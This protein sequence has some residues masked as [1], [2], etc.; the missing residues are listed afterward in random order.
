MRL[1]TLS[2]LARTHGIAVDNLPTQNTALLRPHVQIMDD[3][4]DH[5]V[6]LAKFK[7]LRHF[8][9]SPEAVARLTYEAIVDAAAD[10]VRYLELRFSP[11]ALARVQ[12]FPLADVTDW[13]IEATQQASRVCQIEV[14]LIVTLLRHE[15]LSLAQEVARVAFDRADKG[16]VGLDLAGDEVKFSAMP[17]REIFQEANLRQMGV[18][19]HAGEWTNADSVRI[20]VEE[21]GAVRLGHG[22]RVIDDE[23]V[24]EM[25]RGRQ[26]ALELCLTSNVQ[27]GAVRSM[28]RHPAGE[29][30]RRGALVTL[31]TDDPCVSDCTL[32]DEYVAAVNDLDFSVGELHQVTK[33]AAQA[34]FLPPA[35]RL[36]LE[37]KVASWFAREAVPAF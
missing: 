22:V 9:R 25:V 15:E 13:V 19:I 34:A 21:M 35:R 12:G 7:V 6:F 16:I 23:E 2:D 4:Q 29:L 32:T 5:E 3:P 20:A 18:T 36:E 26:V 37:Q 30:L 14:G 17:F 27:T 11:Q 10:N 24:L 33:N 1:Q 28:R 8:Y 31:N